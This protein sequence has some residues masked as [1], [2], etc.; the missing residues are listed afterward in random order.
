MARIQDISISIT[1][2]AKA[3]E[4]KSFSKPLILGSPSAEGGT[5]KE[6]A[7]L[8]DIAEDFGT[9]TPEYKMAS[10]IFQQNNRPSIIAL[11]RREEGD[12]IEQSLNKVTAINNSWYGLLIPE[13]EA[14]YLNRAGAWAQSNRKFF[15]GCS[16]DVTAV[17][18]L[19]IIR[20]RDARLIH[21]SPLDFPDC[22][23]V[24]RCLASQPGSLTWKWKTLIGQSVC[25]FG[26]TDLNYIRANHGQALQEQSGQ[27]FT[28]EGITTAGEYIDVIIGMDWIES[29]LQTGLLGL[30]LNNDI[31][32]FD[33]VGISQVESVFIDVFSR[34]G[35]NKIVAEATTESELA[36]SYDGRY[37]FWLNIPE[38]EDVSANDRAL[39]LLSGCEFEYTLAGAI[40]EVKVKG[41]III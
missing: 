25:N 15:F 9:T 31:I 24:G 26:I 32:S 16:D 12:T 4:K 21:S 1:S 13:R 39:R 22:A 41:K 33:N 20:D 35:K 8:P 27:V 29:E 18:K 36:E 5:Y 34:A 23:W 37:L 10:A 2:G 7:E 11:Y 14:V 6:Y 28:N 3:L 30:F 17:N 38:R 19:T 40:H